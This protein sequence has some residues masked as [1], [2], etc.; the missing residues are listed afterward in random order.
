MARWQPMAPAGRRLCIKLAALILLDNFHAK[1]DF[2]SSPRPSGDESPRRSE[3]KSTSTTTK[4]RVPGPAREKPP[5]VF[6]AQMNAPFCSTRPRSR[7][8]GPGPH[9]ECT[10]GFSHNPFALPGLRTSLLSS[11]RL[12]DFRRS[13]AAVAL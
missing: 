12:K 8:Y 7:A 1:V 11:A 5:G 2:K 13:A 10:P 3:K 6:F 9:V 4:L